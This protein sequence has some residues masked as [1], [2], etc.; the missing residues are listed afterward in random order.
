MENWPPTHKRVRNTNLGLVAR[1][2][3]EFKAS[4]EAG[5]GKQDEA[6]PQPLAPGTPFLRK[7]SAE[8]EDLS[9]IDGRSLKEGEVTGAK[10]ATIGSV[11]LHRQHPRPEGE[12]GD[13]ETS[14]VEEIV[15]GAGNQ[16][17]PQ[18]LVD[19]AWRNQQ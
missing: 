2:E 18:D 16:Q 4:R 5:M 7:G 1:V 19:Q 3:E 12:K 14:P 10:D 11:V 8:V 6:W 17:M 13:A 15:K 9:A